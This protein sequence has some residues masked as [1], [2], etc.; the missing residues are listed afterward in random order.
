MM[1]PLPPRYRH[2]C[3]EVII[4]TVCL[5]EPLLFSAT[6]IVLAC[7]NC[8]RLRGEAQLSSCAMPARQP[9]QRQPTPLSGRAVGSG[10]L[11]LLR[12]STHKQAR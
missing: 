5:L 9:A 1:H 7:F 4:C 2:P 6:H 8:H 10:T 11:L 3:A 12:G